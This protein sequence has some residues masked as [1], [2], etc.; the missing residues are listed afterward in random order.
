[1][2]F[3]ES[4]RFSDSPLIIST[5]N[6]RFL[7]QGLEGT[8][9]RMVTERRWTGAKYEY[10]VDFLADDATIMADVYTY[11]MAVKGSGNSFRF[12]DWFD[13]KSLENMAGTVTKDDQTLGTG[14]DSE[15]DFQ[16]IKTYTKGANSTVRRVRKPVSGTVLVAIDGALQTETTHYTIDNTTGVISFVTPP[17]SGEVVTAGYEFDVPCR[18]DG[19]SLEM[20]LEL[21][22][23]FRVVGLRLV[24][25]Y[26]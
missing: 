25:V 24:E 11:F 7:T 8:S 23:Q 18:F 12:K 10:S 3:L 17:A 2:A 26:L 14:D 16:L 21:S 22:T 6:P 9:G 1:M 19:D 5:G 13:Y 15:T 4:P 20:V